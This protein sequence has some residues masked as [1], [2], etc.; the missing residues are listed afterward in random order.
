MTGSLEKENLGKLNRTTGSFDDDVCPICNNCGW[1]IVEENGQ[2]MAIECSCGI[3]KKT[4]HNSRLDFANIPESFKDVRLSNFKKTV[5][6]RQESRDMI[7]EIAKAIKYY[8]QNLESMKERGIGLYFY[9][10]TKGSGKTRLA[11]SI[12]NELIENHNCRVKFSTSIQ[13]LNEITNTWNDRSLSESKLI[14]DLMSTEILIIDDFGAETLKDWKNEKFY[15]IIN[16]RYVDRKITIFTSNMSLDDLQYDERI[17]N[18]IKERVLQIPFP[19]ESVRE[20]IAQ[21]LK[22]ELMKGV[23]SDEQGRIEENTEKRK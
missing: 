23:I 10:G 7:V 21:D 3:R 9:S 19:E 4:I 14:H 5:Y 18:R 6:R 2:R 22:E 16:G 13:I 20:V 15:E 12:A 17:K 8:M 1:V 11:A